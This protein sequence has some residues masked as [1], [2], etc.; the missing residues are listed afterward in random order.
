MSDTWR[1]RWAM[2]P[3]AGLLIGGVLLPILLTI[4]ISV[5]QTEA[6]TWDTPSGWTMRYHA[7]LLSESSGRALIL[8]TLL[9]GIGIAI[10]TLLVAL[11]VA[12]WLAEQSPRVRGIAV[13]VILLPKLVSALV[14]VIGLM[15]LLGPGGPLN[16][17]LMLLGV[18]ADPLPLTNGPAGAM[19][20][21]MLLLFPYAAL[22]LTLGRSRIDPL[23]IQAARSLGATPRQVLWRVIL[24]QM[25]PMIRITSVLMLIWATGAILGP[26][27][28]GRPTDWGLAV[29]VQ[30]QLFERLQLP[31]AAAAA[32]WMLILVGTAALG[33]WQ[34]PVR[35]S[36]PRN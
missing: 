8:G 5:A 28:F 12:L 27:F 33:L 4:R 18:I 31:R 13:L 25:G 21:E 23:G 35:R 30:R 2:L 29:E 16:S 3:A 19:L 11:P 15:W 20:V 9:R 6:G 36:M 22:M 1:W 10:G 32:V 26:W 17:G 14:L 7:E 34:R 24:P